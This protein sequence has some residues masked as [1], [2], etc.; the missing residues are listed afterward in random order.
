M[1]E[2]PETEKIIEE[3]TLAPKET[4]EEDMT[5]FSPDRLKKL[6][7]ETDVAHK[8]FLK[9]KLFMQDSYMTM[10]SSLEIL[11]DNTMKII[12]ELQKTKF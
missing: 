10:Y 5:V 8:E 3:E 7:D 9:H 12:E 11:A 4:V 6:M 2:I 1:E